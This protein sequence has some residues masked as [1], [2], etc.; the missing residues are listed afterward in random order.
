MFLWKKC[1]GAPCLFFL[2]LL[3]LY[4]LALPCLPYFPM[5]FCCAFYTCYR[6]CFL[7]MNGNSLVPPSRRERVWYTSSAFWGLFLNSI[8]P[9]RF[10][11]CGLHVIIMWHCAM[12]ICCCAWER[13]MR[14]NAKT[15]RRHAMLH[16]ACCARCI[17]GPFPP[18]GWD[19]GTRL[20]LEKTEIVIRGVVSNI[21]CWN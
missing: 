1:T 11:P 9:I 20:E 5:Q 4:F 16:P 14:C 10:T 19:L 13:L 2:L 12:A 21:W 15:M 18:W 6:Y 3:L 8:A 7:F 17:P